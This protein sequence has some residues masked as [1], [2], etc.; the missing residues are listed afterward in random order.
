[1]SNKS[2]RSAVNR[3]VSLL[4]DRSLA[5]SP[6]HFLGREDALLAELGISRPTLRQ[7]AR[8]LE[9]EHLVAV[10]RGARGGFFA[11]RPQ[12]GDVIRAPARFLRLNGAT[13]ADVHAATKSIAE[14]VGAL[15][16]RCNDPELRGRLDA[17]RDSIDANDSP[18]L[19]IAAETALA[20]LL[21]EMSGNPAAK[22]FIEIGYTFGRDEHHLHF[23]QSAE[24]RARA[25]AL[26]RGV[27]DAVLAHDSEVARLMM[28]RRSAL[29][30][31]WLAREPASG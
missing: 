2:T 14:E 3:A 17:F 23:Y 16:A 28:Q 11:Q 8:I 18:G 12:A 26:Q 13:V 22:L 1:M 4:A 31:E 5:A 6:G 27:C 7:A 15:A 19:V 25:R 24:D 20:R 9:S 29:V 21:A 30:A 10:R